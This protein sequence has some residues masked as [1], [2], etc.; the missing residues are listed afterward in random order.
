M[1]G[2]NH[3]LRL[4]EQREEGDGTRIQKL[5]ERALQSWNSDV[6]GGVTTQLKLVPLSGCNEVH[7]GNTERCWSGAN[8]SY[9]GEGPLLRWHKNSKQKE[10]V[11]VFWDTPPPA[12]SSSTSY[13][14]TKEKSNLQSH[15]SSITGQIIWSWV[16]A[17]RQLHGLNRGAAPAP[18][19]RMVL[20]PEQKSSYWCSTWDPSLRRIW[21]SFC[22]FYSDHLIFPN[23]FFLQA[24]TIKSFLISPGGCTQNT[25]IGLGYS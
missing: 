2:S 3:L 23:N 8:Y 16:G 7:S 1:T 15:S 12:P 14:W 5:E 19:L 18:S 22:E 4:G 6:W 11:N 10:R 13:W 20:L 24:E 17:K 9:Q 25:L 21:F